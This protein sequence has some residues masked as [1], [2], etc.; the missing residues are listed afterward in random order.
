MPAA[1][2]EALTAGSNMSNVSGR[3]PNQQELV[4]TIRR[5]GSDAVLGV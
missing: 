1:P 2:R 3:T 5:R 4:W